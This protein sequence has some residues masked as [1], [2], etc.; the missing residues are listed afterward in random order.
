MA[1]EAIADH[2]IEVPPHP[3]HHA[4]ARPGHFFVTDKEDRRVKPGDGDVL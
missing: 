3:I 1:G 4:R 2:F